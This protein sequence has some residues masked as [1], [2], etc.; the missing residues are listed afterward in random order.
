MEKVC[1]CVRT[2]VFL[3]LSKCKLGRLGVSPT[4]SKMDEYACK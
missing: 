2:Q 3:T 4:Y 1:V